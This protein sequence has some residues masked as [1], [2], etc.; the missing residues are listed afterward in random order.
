MNNDAANGDSKS[1]DTAFVQQSADPCVCL[2][3]VG[4]ITPHNKFISNH[5]VKEI[6]QDHI[7]SN[8]FILDTRDM[9]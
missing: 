8:S 3:Q 5:V 9:P 1:L 2:E 4:S 7:G 6:G